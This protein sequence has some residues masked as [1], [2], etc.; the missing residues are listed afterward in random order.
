MTSQEERRKMENEAIN[1]AKRFRG[2][3]GANDITIMDRLDNTFPKGRTMTDVECYLVGE[4]IAYCES[5]AYD[6]VS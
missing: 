4:I 6:E 3:C 1:I 5:V 2:G